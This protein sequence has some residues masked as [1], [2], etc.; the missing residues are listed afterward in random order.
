MYICVAGAEPAA[1]ALPLLYRCLL[2][3][4][5]VHYW[6]AAHALMAPLTMMEADL[7][8]QCNPGCPFS[9]Y[10]T[11]VVVWMTQCYM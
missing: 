8:P 4:L 10:P 9:E 1:H 2:L 5:L 6:C 7:G 3:V 11:G